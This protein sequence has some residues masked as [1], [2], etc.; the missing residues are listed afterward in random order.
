MHRLRVSVY[1]LSNCPL[2]HWCHSFVCY[3]NK[4]RWYCGQ[5][6]CC[7]GHTIQRSSLIKMYA[8]NGPRSSVIVSRVLANKCRYSKHTCTGCTFPKTHRGLITSPN[9]ANSIL[10]EV[11]VTAP[12]L[13]IAGILFGCE[14]L[15]CFY[16]FHILVNTL[17][18]VVEWNRLM[19]NALLE[20]RHVLCPETELR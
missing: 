17:G 8:R 18:A 4:R 15:E 5:R 19:D 3:E 7:T 13:E 6:A 11:I 2:L 16:E 14:Q 1:I 12:V 20:S 9:G 10:I